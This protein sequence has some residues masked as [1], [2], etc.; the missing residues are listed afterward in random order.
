MIS[1]ELGYLDIV[2]LLVS[3]GC[4]TALTNDFGKSGLDLA[5]ASQRNI[6]SDFLHEQAALDPALNA[7]LDALNMRPEVKS[8][9]RDELQ[10]LPDCLD[11]WSVDRFEQWTHIGGGEIGDIFKVSNVFPPLE[12]GDGRQVKTLVWTC[13]SV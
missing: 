11:F 4:S 8:S 5:M 6:V 12:M 13:K 7:E 9:R 10:V 2:R 1:C 3:A